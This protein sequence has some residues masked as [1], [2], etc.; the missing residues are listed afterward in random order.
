MKGIQI[1]MVVSYETDKDLIS[2]QQI[3]KRNTA[4]KNPEEWR[5]LFNENVCGN[6]IKKISIFDDKSEIW[7][8]DCVHTIKGI[9][10]WLHVFVIGCILPIDKLHVINKNCVELVVTNDTCFCIFPI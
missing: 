2:V 7:N 4:L 1:I 9:P 10:H 8:I 6:G 3:R 5:Q